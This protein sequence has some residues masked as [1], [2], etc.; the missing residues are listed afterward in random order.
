[1]YEIGLQSQQWIQKNFKLN[2]IKLAAR[3]GTS[4]IK[5]K[6]SDF[7]FTLFYTIF[8][9]FCP[10][11]SCV[12]DF[13]IEIISRGEYLIFITIDNETFQWVYTK[14]HTS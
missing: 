8:F 13:N 11:F 7:Q 9:H 1:M 4:T 3:F 10:K 12:H 5:E 2:L 14:Y 6:K